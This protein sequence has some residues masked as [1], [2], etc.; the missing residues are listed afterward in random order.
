MKSNK[1]ILLEC[2]LLGC[3]N[4]TEYASRPSWTNCIKNLDNLVTD[5]RPTKRVVDL[6]SIWLKVSSKCSW[7]LLKIGIFLKCRSITKIPQNI[8]ARHIFDIFVSLKYRCQILLRLQVI[9]FVDRLNSIA[10][11]CCPLSAGVVRESVARY[12]HHEVF[13]G[14]LITV[15]CVLMVAVW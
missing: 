11:L 7:I 15:K 10:L 6:H 14:N 8:S 4:C 2:E 9:I 13:S 12:L 3:R 1:R 5:F